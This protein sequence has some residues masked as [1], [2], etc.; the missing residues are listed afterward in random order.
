[1]S[2]A[3]Q[4]STSQNHSARR[5][6]YSPPNTLKRNTSTS[7]SNVSKT[8]Q[9][10]LADL[11]RKKIVENSGSPGPGA[12][13]PNYSAIYKSPSYTISPR[14]PSKSK[15]DTPSP[16]TYSSQK[17]RQVGTTSPLYSIA[18]RCP[19]APSNPHL[20]SNDTPSPA[21]Y[22]SQKYKQVG[23]AS[24]VYTIS[25]R[26][27][28]TV[29]P[30][31]PGP[32]TY[33]KTPRYP[34]RRLST[35]PVTKPVNNPRSRPVPVS[36]N[37]ATAG[38]S[39][40]SMST[41]RSSVSDSDRPHL[42]SM[43][44]TAGT[45]STIRTTEAAD[46]STTQ[47]GSRHDSFRDDDQQ[48]EDDGAAPGPSNGERHQAGG[49]VIYRFIH[50]NPADEEIRAEPAHDEPLQ[51]EEPQAESAS[52]EPIQTEEVQAESVHDEPLQMEEVKASP[53]HDEPLQTEEIH[54]ESVHDEP[55]QTEEVQV[56]SIHDEPLQTEELHG[57]SAHDEPLQ[58]EKVHAESVRDEP[59][60]TEP[61]ITSVHDEPLQTEEVQAESV[62][63]EPLQTEDAIVE[64]VHDEPLKE[65]EKD[66]IPGS[67]HSE[68]LR[69]EEHVVVYEVIQDELSKKE[70]DA[71]MHE[72]TEKE[73][74]QHRESVTEEA[75][76]IRSENH[77]V[78]VHREEAIAL[79]AK[80]VNISNAHNDT[81]SE[82]RMTGRRQPSVA[83]SFSEYGSSEKQQ[84]QNNPDT[85]PPFHNYLLLIV[86]SMAFFVYIM[87]S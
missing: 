7:H 55:L 3:S 38:T 73:P 1:M 70:K 56:E 53:V 41:L 36:D 46:G 81:M 57:E 68:S 65:A 17:Y 66:T 67:S 78:P 71:S 80:S 83:S 62:H 16:A 11:S 72:N 60:Q 75:H 14:Y 24:P 20:V 13:A 47:G 6:T 86:V 87:L 82:D 79:S 31:S 52:D 84:A 37:T 34:K 33:G 30:S 74:S 63:D 50:N 69:D 48:A 15:A 4:A 9:S 32:G 51:T 29:P 85:K 8:S 26:S 18:S 12:Y 58:T 28:Q 35:E 5:P 40:R 45:F 54:I 39:E 77:K 61:Q 76:P 42:E 59:L 2:S 43:E 23:T 44:V 19:R 25:T 64:S 22:S 10:R 27:P 21:T 49:D